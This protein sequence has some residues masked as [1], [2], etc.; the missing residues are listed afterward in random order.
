[1]S[2]SQ[3]RLSVD[4]LF[5]DLTRFIRLREGSPALDGWPCVL[6]DRMWATP[7]D[8]SFALTASGSLCL[9]TGA[10]L[11]FAPPPLERA[12]L[13][14]S[15]VPASGNASALAGI[16]PLLDSPPD[17]RLLAPPTR[18][19]THGA[20]VALWVTDVGHAMRLRS[21][22]RSRATQAFRAGPRRSPFHTSSA[23]ADVLRNSSGGAG[24]T[25]ALPLVSPACASSRATR[26]ANTSASPLPSPPRSPLA[27]APP[28][29][30]RMWPTIARP[31]WR[32]VTSAKNGTDWPA[33]SPPAPLPPPCVVAH[34][35]PTPSLSPPSPLLGMPGVGAAHRRSVSGSHPR[36]EAHPG[37]PSGPAG[38][39]TL[40]LASEVCSRPSSSRLRVGLEALAK[41]AV[42][43]EG[44][45]REGLAREVLALACE[46]DASASAELAWLRGVACASLLLALSSG[47]VAC[48]V[49][50]AARRE[51]RAW[52]AERLQILLR[53][54]LARGSS[55]RTAPP[56]RSPL[57][58][59]RSSES[60]RMHAHAAREKEAARTLPRLGAGE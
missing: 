56:S 8:G 9:L 12:L 26:A 13:R 18:P 4:L 51:R 46:L 27:D 33:A 29:L 28:L 5:L 40:K 11:I 24:I 1:M 55:G 38:P 25:R 19:P 45:A 53:H 54:L 58:E 60:R 35:T 49:V 23:R 34:A 42:A 3:V 16:P 32:V 10:A 36:R 31:R 39:G 57:A 30:R 15:H 6:S 59:S 20:K 50:W 48:G 37:W 7:V 22:H 44:L 47:A 52:R 14:G 17:I 43:K 2:G 41:E 21:R